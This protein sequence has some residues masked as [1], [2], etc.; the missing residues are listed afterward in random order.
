MYSLSFTGFKKK[1]NIKFLNFWLSSGIEPRTACLTHKHSA[2]ELGSIPVTAKH[3][4]TS[5][6]FFKKK[7]C[8]RER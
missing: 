5:V 1:N 2:T 7:D 8:E 3:F 6:L 4:L